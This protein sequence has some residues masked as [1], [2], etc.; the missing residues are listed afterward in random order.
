MSTEEIEIEHEK[1]LK[2]G[3]KS[4]K[5]KVKESMVPLIA[6]ATP[7]THLEGL[8]ENKVHDSLYIILSMI[9]SIFIAAG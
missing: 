7:S 6:A 5:G 9:A 8:K 1:A 3:E 2:G 4:I